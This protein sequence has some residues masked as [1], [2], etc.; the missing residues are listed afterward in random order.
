MASSNLTRLTRPSLARLMRTRLAWL[1]ERLLAELAA[2]GFPEFRMVHTQV[3]AHLDRDGTRPSELAR[4]A[5]MTRQAMHQLVRQL[6]DEGL[7]VV[8]DDPD[9]RSARLVRPTARGGAA[10]DAAESAFARIESALGAAIGDD[11]LVALRSTL[12]EE[13][14]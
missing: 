12:E 10:M 3:L 4:R 11:R 6:R 13:W 5:G 8:T 14:G 9:D 2:A 7:L 1:D